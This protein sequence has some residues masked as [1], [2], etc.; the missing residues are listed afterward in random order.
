MV[1]SIE[2]VGAVCQ[3][4][5]IDAHFAKGGEFE[6][7]R[8]DYELATIQEMYDEYRS[9][10]FGDQVRLLDK[11][12]ANDR[13]KIA[14]SVGAFWFSGGASIQPARLARGLAE[15]V[16]R[17]GGTIY[18][19]TRVTDFTTGSKPSLI[20]NRGTVNA[21]VIVLAGEAYL[22]QLPQTRRAIIPI[23]SRI[24]IT[25]PLS[26]A[27]W[28]EIGWKDRDVV[29]GFG[30]L[31]GYLNHT[32]DQRLMFGA[33]RGFY[34]Y[35]SKITDAIDR[36][37]KVFKHARD[38]ALTWFPM[39]K[40]VRFTHSWGGVLGMPRDHMPTMSFNRST[41][42]ATGRGYTGEGV[43]TANLS[44]RVLADL[45]TETDSDL[46]LLPM[47]SHQSPDW[48]PEPFRWAGVN[49][50]FKSRLRYLRKVEQEGGYPS[51]KTLAQR[52]FDF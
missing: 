32:A 41:G 40:G 13:I 6:V 18:E 1:D 49:F 14:D 2:N 27:I 45:I 43:G 23:T 51:R 8:A 19:Q 39:L 36:D 52:L 25:E 38:A 5:G 9:I 12:E 17:H 28:D 21:K 31:G 30:L 15:A 7:A 11:T 4:E 10:G 26:D 42:V 44:G 46:T 47:T 50:V 3:E 16:E 37:E 35:H 48:E 20:T 29:G 33:Y 34:P 24:V 22:S